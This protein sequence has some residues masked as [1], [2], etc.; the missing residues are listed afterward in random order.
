M[1]KRAVY[2]IQSS[3]WDREWFMTF[4]DYRFR[5]VGIM[6]RLLDRISAGKMAGPFTADGQAVLLEDYLEARPY[7]REE[8]RRTRRWETPGRYRRSF[9][10]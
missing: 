10:R 8:F 1:S 4:Q 3:H 7:R 6:D 9:R 5:L 2:F